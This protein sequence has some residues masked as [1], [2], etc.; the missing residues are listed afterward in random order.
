M[1]EANGHYQMQLDRI[2]RMAN[3]THETMTHGMGDVVNAI[4][5]L[6]GK[7]DGVKTSIDVVSLQNRDVV[8]WL[9]WVVCA[10][11][12]GSK[13]IELLRGIIHI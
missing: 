7:V 13:L 12:L 1:T 9:L 8:R 3:D 11:A 4:K 5:D 6:T 2:E 10:I